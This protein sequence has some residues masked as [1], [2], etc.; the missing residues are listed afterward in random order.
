M[1]F[2]KQSL[3]KIKSFLI[4]YKFPLL[5]LIGAGFLGNV[6]K[7]SLFFGVDFLFGSIATLLI[8]YFYGIFWGT[9]ASLIAASYTY[10]LWGHFYAAILLILET[11]FV[12]FWLKKNQDNLVLLDGIYWLIIGSPLVWFFYGQKLNIPVNQMWLVLLKQTINGISNALIA[13]LIIHLFIFFISA[14]INENHRKKIALSLEQAIF[15]LLVA[16]VLL[17]SLAL[18]IFHG[19]S[20][21]NNI[22]VEIEKDV[23]IVEYALKSSINLW[24][25]HNIQS[26][27]MLTELASISQSSANLQQNLEVF[28]EKFPALFQL[29]I[30]DDQGKIILSQPQV[31][32]DDKFS[33]FNQ[34]NFQNI[35]QNNQ[36]LKP[37]IF[38]KFYQDQKTLAEYLAFATPIFNQNEEPKIIYGSLKLDALK[39]IIKTTVIDP[40]FQLFLLDENENIITSNY[41]SVNFLDRTKL[42]EKGN[43]I[44]INNKVSQW[45]PHGKMPLMVKWKQS[46]YFERLSFDHQFPFTISVQIPLFSYIERLELL[47]IQNLR[48]MLILSVIALITAMLISRHLVKPILNLKQLTT[49]IPNKLS[50]DNL[51][52]L[53]QSDIQEINSLTNNFADM[54][55]VLKQQF[56]QVKNVKESLELR[57]EKRTEE[58]LNLNDELAKEIMQRQEIE[59][60]L[61]IQEERY[62]LA[63]SGTNDGVWDW[64][65]ETNKVYY[66][67]SW[68]GILGYENEPLSDDFSSWSD[69]IHPEDLERVLQDIKYHLKGETELYENSHRIKHKNNNYIWISAKGKCL[70]NQGN[71]P[72]RLVGT[73]T[74]I[75]E[76]IKAQAQLKIAKEE[77]ETANQAKSEFLATMSHEIRTPMNAVIGMTN[78]L[79]DTSLNSQQQEFT[80]IIRSSGESLLTI[81]N[82]ILD[83]SKIESGKLELEKQPFNL[84]HCVE[85]SLDLLTSKAT[86]KNI[87]LAYLFENDVSENIEGDVTRLRQ[88]LVNLLNNAI[89]FTEKGEVV[90]HI[91]LNSLKNDDQNSALND[92]NRQ[93]Y[94]IL[95]AIKDT[96]IGIPQEKM[97]RL[98]KAFSQVDASTSRHYGGTGLGLVIS[99]RLTELMDGQMWVES[100]GFVAG[101]PPANFTITTANNNNNGSIFYFTIVTQA[102]PIAE[103]LKVKNVLENKRLLIVDDNLTNRQVLILQGQSFGMTPSAFASPEEVLNTLETKEE[104]DIAIL[105][106][107]MPEMDGLMLAKKMREY[108]QAKN[109]PLILLTSI[110][111]K[112]LAEKEKDI[113]WSACLSKPIKQSQLFNIFM[114]IFGQDENTYYQINPPSSSHKFDPELAQKYPLKILLA[115][116]NVVNQK[117]AL[118]I[119]KRLGYRG[120][121]VANGLEVLEAIARQTYDV[122]LMDVQMPEMDG[123][124]ATRH[125]CQ[126]FKTEISD[127]PWIIAMTANA[128]QGDRQI[129]LEAG[130]NDYLS[131]PIPINDLISVLINCFNHLSFHNIPSHD[132]TT[133]KAQLIIMKTENILDQNA[134][135]DLLEM[136]GDDAYDMI[137]DII[138]CYLEDSP[139]H[140]QQLDEGLKDNNAKLLAHVAHTLKSSSGSLGAKHLSQLCQELENLGKSEILEKTE[141]LVTQIKTEYEQVA[142]ALKEYLI[143]LK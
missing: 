96:G 110:E 10:F 37:E 66:S 138:D 81:I 6:F 13:S 125:I 23:Q 64:N 106:M 28:Q 44:F 87:E 65:L 71:I 77:A 78:L 95:F 31:N 57:V 141:D 2:K 47:Y 67:P 49:D 97:N 29:Y 32:L 12:G 48:L 74:D 56:N 61:R 101:D 142:L 124:E 26:F 91:K 99:K 17:P 92:Q 84:R 85:E 14:K 103:D 63:I 136:A 88:V 139:H 52:D 39:S 83:F 11:F 107:Q 112:H 9:L 58:L 129:C 122:V 3:S 76:Q 114:N 16:F 90:I 80:E 7:I 25:D 121:V 24:F 20:L 109:I 131:K 75:T 73:I 68:M 105:D 123:L 137:A 118:N 117:V 128:M 42:R 36:Q 89:K 51:I 133:E 143:Q 19:K 60:A 30:T 8:V 59:K 134:L 130:M 34:F 93:K 50:T 102:M 126:E 55:S 70:R 82:D 45:L 108:P 119:L 46:F 100:N 18:T 15:N 69:R 132:I 135:K 116:D 35:S 120:D 38:T 140:L 94:E 72:Y 40:R 113:N 33:L 54:I 86:E 4:N 43:V 104:F 53:P 22:K 1:N 79:L 5:L 115:E 21:V 62:D 98:F 111:N 127:R 27:E 41:S